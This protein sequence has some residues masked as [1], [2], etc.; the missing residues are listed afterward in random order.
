MELAICLGVNRLQSLQKRLVK[1]EPQSQIKDR[2]LQ[3]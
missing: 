1:G 2:E 3:I